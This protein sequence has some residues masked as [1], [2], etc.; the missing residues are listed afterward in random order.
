MVQQGPDSLSNWSATGC[1]C[2]M[3]SGSDSLQVQLR[4]EQLSGWVVFDDLSLRAG[5]AVCASCWAITWVAPAWSPKPVE[6]WCPTCAIVQHP[7]S[8]GDMPFGERSMLGDGNNIGRQ[9]LHQPHLHPGQV[10]GAQRGLRAAGLQRPLQ[11]PFIV[12]SHNFRCRNKQ[13]VIYLH[14]PLFI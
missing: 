8:E 11:R 2:V 3:P 13:R 12:S 1:N 5:Q 4:V 6:R 10:P 14:F 9:S 7:G